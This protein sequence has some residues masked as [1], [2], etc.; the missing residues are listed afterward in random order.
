MSYGSGGRADK[1]GNRY[2][3][4]WVAS[5][6][7]KLCKEQITSLIHEP[8]G[9]LA[10][11]IDLQIFHNDTVELHQCKG[12]NAQKNSWDMSD[13]QTKQAFE[14]MKSHL[15]KGDMYYYKWISPYP[16][17]AMKTLIQEATNSD[18]CPCVF[19]NHQ[20]KANPGKISKEVEKN[21]KSFCSYMGL[22]PI[23][24]DDTPNEHDIRQ[25]RSYLKRIEFI[26][27]DDSIY[28]RD[29]II[30]Q[31]S[32]VFQGISIDVY[33][34]LLTYIS[35]NN[36]FSSKINVSEINSYLTSRK[37]YKLDLSNNN[38]VWPRIN[39]LNKEFENEFRP[40]DCGLIH[41]TEVDDIYN[42]IANGE[43][44]ILHGKPGA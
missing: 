3:N 42:Y 12:S 6:L 41:R 2:E 8:I 23:N 15:S 22:E 16:C 37:M 27:F 34:T 18:D 1:F 7:L 17:V 4:R 20:I 9:D 28:A 44:V 24:S 5:Q 32:D 25:A 10:D 26:L 38:Q 30:E 31:I 29:S 13:L 21:F 43:S 33:E 11:G 36:R 40:L 14:R 35:E 39:E 19:Y